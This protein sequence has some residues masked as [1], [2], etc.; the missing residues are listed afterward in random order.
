MN[1]VCCIT[2]HT[3]GL[4]KFLYNHFVDEGWNVIGFSRSNGYNI[5]QDY[6]RISEV[7]KG[8]QLFIN[9]TYANGL[10]QQLLDLTFGNVNN[11]VVCGSVASD[12]PDPTLP[13]Y[14]H[15]KKLLEQRCNELSDVKSLSTLLLLKLT[16]SSYR[17]YETIIKTI[18]F[19]L[20]TPSITQIKF[21][22]D[23]IL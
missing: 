2:G 20:E 13:K 11:I 16:S 17:D 15:H 18:E 5:E 9:N 22:V 8:S 1:R 19:W 3:H 14:S 6:V 4:G 23:D 21:T 12:H 10:Q 7:I